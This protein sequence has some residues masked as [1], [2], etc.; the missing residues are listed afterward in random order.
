MTSKRRLKDVKKTSKIK[1]E[2]YIEDVLKRRFGKRTFKTLS[3][4]ILDTSTCTT[5]ATIRGLFDVLKMHV[6]LK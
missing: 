5:H 4:H 2:T 6:R 1:L 3:R